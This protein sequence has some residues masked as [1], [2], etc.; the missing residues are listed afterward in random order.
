[1]G[2]NFR[3]DIETAGSITLILQAFMIPAAFADGPVK[4]TII[5]G[6]DVRWSPSVDYLENVTLPILNLMGYRAKTNLIQRG[7]YPRGGGILEL[8]IDPVKKLK[9]LNVSELKFDRINGISH[10]VKLP[11]HVAE[12]QAKSAEE[13]SQMQVTD[14][15]IK[16]EQFKQVYWARFRYFSLD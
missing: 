2:G 16:I 15:N 13:D 11:E 14:S 10:A 8:E 9:P 12:R 5:G 7:H 6:T 4:I 1:M 3:I